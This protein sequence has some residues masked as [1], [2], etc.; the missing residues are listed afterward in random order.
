MQLHIAREE[1]VDIFTKISSFE[2]LRR[3]DASM[4]TAHLAATYDTITEAGVSNIL[5]LCEALWIHSGDPAAPHAELTGGDCSNGFVDTLRALR[6]TNVCDILS[7][8]MMQKIDAYREEFDLEGNMNWVIGSDH[9]GAVF[10]QNVARWTNS[11]HD[12]TE[13]GGVDGKE[14]IW[15]RFVIEPGNHVLQVEE[16]ITTTQ[17]LRAVREGVRK[18]NPHPVT[19]TSYVA[20]LVHRSDSY[21]FEGV[22]IIYLAHYDIKKWRREECPLCAQGSKRIKPKQNWAELTGK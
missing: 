20:T 5:S 13:K 18:G 17:T 6:H 7:Y 9:A 4:A 19:F 8:H 10:S 2:Q 21:E 11:M 14:Q 22:P 1:I 3:F 15:K 12:F 16:L